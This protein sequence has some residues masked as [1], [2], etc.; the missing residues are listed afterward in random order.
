MCSV[1]AIAGAGLALQTASTVYSAK[2]Q[3]KASERNETSALLAEREASKDISLLQQQTVDQATKTIFETDRQARS[4]QALARV[5]AGE[6]G[7]SGISVEAL[8]GDLDRKLG[9]FRSGT[10]RN[11]EAALASLQ[12][13]KISGRTIAQQRIA[14]VPG[15]SPFAVGLSLAGPGLAFWQGQIRRNAATSVDKVGT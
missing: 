5:S 4:T 8:F 15:A 14:N 13:E 3:N 9:E 2:A 10:A 12:R 1:L 7:V 11:L 6:A